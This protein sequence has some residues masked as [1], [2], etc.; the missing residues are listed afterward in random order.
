[1]RDS[2]EKAS[3]SGLSARRVFAIARKEFTHVLRDWRSL[4]LALAIPVMLILLFGYAL[5]LDVKNVPTIVYDASGTP[6]SRDFVRL[7]GGSTYFTFVDR[8]DNHR[9]IARAID[10]GRA[11]VAIVIPT[12]FAECVNAGRKAEIQVIVDGSDANTGRLVTG[13]V[14]AV[15]L[16]YYRNLVVKRAEQAGGGAVSMPVS[17]EHR[18]WYNP[19]LRSTNNIIPGIIAIVM[20]VIAAI[21]TST[22]VAKE[23]ELGT[24]EQLI[25]TPVRVQELVVGKLTP[26]FVIGFLD[27]T[28]AVAMGQWIFGVPLRGNAA[29][30]FLM[31]AVFLIGALS[32]GFMI[33]AMLKTQVLAT[34]IALLST[35]LPT[36]LL[37]GFVFAIENMPQAI[38]AITYFVPARYFIAIMRGIYMKGIGLDVMWF[39]A[40]LLSL[41][42]LFMFALANRKLR[43][44]LD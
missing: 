6:E 37:S 33:S 1:M 31:A 4:T 14:S 12:D 42:A 13:Y 7:F 43:L 23:W 40:L 11:M 36:L 9:D 20:M 24:M 16:I 26:F 21:L 28:V 25:S 44:K 19:E 10:R 17:V 38:R 35:Y 3:T 22:T 41:W 18:A 2:R 34:Q 30:L 5:N 8:C 15:G 29:L 27:V 32:T 39:N